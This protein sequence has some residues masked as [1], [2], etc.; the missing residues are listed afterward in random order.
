MRSFILG[1]AV[2][3]LCRAQAFIKGD[4]GGGG[5]VQRPGSGGDGDVIGGMG[6]SLQN[7]TR[8]PFGLGSEN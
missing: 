5:K 2:K 3:G 1:P 8:Q 6:I 4:A 7:F